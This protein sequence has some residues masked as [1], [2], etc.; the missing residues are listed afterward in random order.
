MCQPAARG[1]SVNLINFCEG[2][3]IP[4]NV[5]QFKRTY[6]P[7]LLPKPRFFSIRGMLSFHGKILLS[8]S[9]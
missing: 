7:Y 9:L 3:G 4:G 5:T 1:V 8:L 6:L 2:D